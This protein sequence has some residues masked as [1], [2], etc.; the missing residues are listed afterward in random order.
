M[1]DVLRS[2]SDWLPLTHAIEAFQDAA[3]TTDTTAVLREVAVVLTWVIALV[4]LGS[5]TLR[6]R[7]S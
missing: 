2:I 5:I 4:A 3:A 1:P 6:R 7:T